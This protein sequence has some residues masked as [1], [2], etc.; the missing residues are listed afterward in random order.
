MNNSY[1]VNLAEGSAVLKFSLTD[2]LR[3]ELSNRGGYEAAGRV[4]TFKVK[5]GEKTYS[6]TIKELR[7]NMTVKI[8]ALSFTHMNS[9]ISA[10]LEFTYAEDGKNFDTSENSV[11]YSGSKIVADA[12]GTN[13]IATAF[14]DLMN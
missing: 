9:D 1:K 5:I 3:K 10:W 8:T 13:A 4:V 12:A 2:E 14:K 11:E 6:A 7:V